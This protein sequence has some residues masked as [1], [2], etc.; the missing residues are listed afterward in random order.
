[1]G[2]KPKINARFATSGHILLELKSDRIHMDT[3]DPGY[4]LYS[5]FFFLDILNGIRIIWV[6]ISIL[7]VY[8][9]SNFQYL[10]PDMVGYQM[11]GFRLTRTM[12]M[13]F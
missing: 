8:Q 2:L 9:K 7:Y 6:F 3:G 5:I 4:V 11:F 1:M 10:D 12:H 13:R